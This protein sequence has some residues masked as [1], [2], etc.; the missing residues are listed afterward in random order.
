VDNILR[1]N[2][3]T[4]DQIDQVILSGGSTKMCR[5]QS[6]LKQ[7]FSDNK[8]LFT[9]SPDEIISLGCAKQCA[10]IKASKA[11]AFQKDD[12]NFKCLSNPI[13]IKVYVTT[14][15]ANNFRFRVKKKIKI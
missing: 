6:L 10:F 8:V 4:E 13:Y 1:S 12:M 14:L 2:N 9:Q 15:F 11:K 7:K 5:L 3:L